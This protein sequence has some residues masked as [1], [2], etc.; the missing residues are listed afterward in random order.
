MKRLILIYIFTLFVDVFAQVPRKAR[1][2]GR[3]EMVVDEPMS[4]GTLPDRKTAPDEVRGISYEKDGKKSFVMGDQTKKGLYDQINYSNNSSYIVKNGKLYGIANKKG[5]IM[6][7]IEFDSIGADYSTDSG[8]IAKQKGKYGKITST[9]E[10]I[11]PI[12]Y[13]KII[14]G[15]KDVTL[16]KNNKNLTQ[17]IFNKRHKSPIGKIEYAELYQNLTIVK[18]NGKF[19]VVNNEI[20]VPFEY[21]SIFLPIKDPKHVPIG[22]INRTFQKIKTPNPLIIHY[23]SITC[24]T[25]QKNNKFGLI[26]NEGKII[27]PVDNDEVY[28]S[29]PFGYYNVKK[30]NLYGIYFS[31]SK[32]KK[33]TEI[34]FDRISVDGYGAVMA[35]KN[36]KMG[37]FNLGGEQIA[38]FEYDNDF[39]LQFS[40]IGYRISKDKKRGIIDQ[41]GK[42][43]V[44][45]IYDDVSTFSWGNGDVFSVKNGEKYGM[46]NRDGKIIIPV[47][48][49][50]IEEL[51][52]NYLVVSPQRK[53]GLYDKTGN[54]IL[55]VEYNWIMKTAT[56]NSS[57]LVMNINEYSFN[58]LDKNNKIILPEDVIEYGYVL[59]EILLKSPIARD[60]LMFVKTK[61]GKYGLLNEISGTLEVPFI[62]DEIIQCTNSSEGITYFSVRKG[63]KYGLINE[64]GEVIIPIKYN[65]I[66]LTFANSTA[67]FT[68]RSENENNSNDFQVVVAKDKKYGTVNLKDEVVIPFQ[69]SFLQRLS[70]SGLFKAKTGNQY[71]ILDKDGNGISKNTFD[72]VAD[73]ELVD[74]NYNRDYMLQS[75]TFSNGKMR[76]IDSKGN[77]VTSEEPMQ[78]HNGYETFDQLK[79]SL[80]V[81]LDSKDNKL[82][83][84]FV[85]KIAPSEH[86]LYYLKQNVFDEKTLDINI[87][88]IKE[89]YLRDLLT[90]K[91]NEW[92]VDTS[93]RYSGYNRSSLYV[94]DYT[95]YTERYG[96]VTNTRT[97]DHAYGDTRFMEK[98]LRNAIKVNGYWIS[99]YF[100]TRGFDRY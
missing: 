52:D 23:Q 34:E 59:D 30:G 19:G 35:S 96:I 11:L 42:I 41:Q 20:I 64:R 24:L 15:N 26:N 82:L 56:P 5:E 13:N 98:L 31:N 2:Q 36:K 66:S 79:F 40:G 29:E 9:G 86:I 93:V 91:Y 49:R 21:D 85:D 45:T 71:Q 51:N 55:P 67:Y 50:Y 87:N 94:T 75:L 100:M 28:N 17:L 61:N 76:V 72:E 22:S 44:P 14:G 90:F 16:V 80:I 70:Y 37:I 77:F 25:L 39:I 62:Y 58:F 95:R 73:F 53:V 27:Y 83:K 48:F 32:D 60:G 54:S 57:I 65:A 81:A 33:I 12:K 7:K 3:G 47:E 78:P 8:F 38:P 10:I 18:S 4:K 43:I 89:K 99:T 6:V 63:N 68:D 92:N 1:S 88:E 84:E 74:E 97:T 46:V 69:Y